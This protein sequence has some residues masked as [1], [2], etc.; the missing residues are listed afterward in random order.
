MA[1]ALSDR[2]GPERQIR[3]V[4][5]DGALNQERAASVTCGPGLA[6]RQRR[7]PKFPR[8][9][10]SLD[11]AAPASDPGAS[12]QPGGR[13]AGSRISTREALRFLTKAGETLAS[14]LDYEATLQAVAD[15]AV[16]RVACFC[17]VDIEEAE[18]VRRLGI[19]HVEPDQI[20]ILERVAMVPSQTESNSRVAWSLESGEPLLISPVSAEWL[21]EIARDEEHFDLLT[22]LAPTSLMLVPLLARGQALGVLALA[23]TRTDRYYQATDLSLARELGRIAAISIDNSR[24]YQEAQNAV[25]ARDEVLRVVSH[26]LRN[27]ISTISMGASH[28]LE[29]APEELRNGP[30]GRVL[31]TIRSSTDRASRMIDDLL[32]VSRIEAGQL[33]IEA[34]PEPIGRLLEEAVETH[35]HIAEKSQIRLVLSASEALLWVIV[36]R[37]RVLQILG[38][39]VGNALKFTPEGGEVEVGAASDGEEVRCYVSDTGPGIPEDQLAHVFDRFWQAR[40]TDRR[41]L[42][43]GLAIVRGL[44]EAHGGRVWVESEI[45][46]GSRFNFTL[47]KV[48]ATLPV[49]AV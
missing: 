37:S 40:R 23:S 31:R 11:S 32:D 29:E 10:L 41:G 42:G 44:V 38:N 15:L 2:Y 5:E 24:L 17:L 27:P 1:P 45:G 21:H 16:P 18:G 47:P 14:T 49:P 22:R 43:L 34:S 20:P 33:A 9:Q 36:D 35:R 13:S 6:V 7:S 12:S 3:L 25:R 8:T 46:H 28:L 4:S 39:L 30:F 26:D 48:P 19:A